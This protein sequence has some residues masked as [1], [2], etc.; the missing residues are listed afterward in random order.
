MEYSI[1]IQFWTSVFFS[2]RSLNIEEHIETKQWT[3]LAFQLLFG[4][5]VDTDPLM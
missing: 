3:K 4:G 1:L 5:G 2:F